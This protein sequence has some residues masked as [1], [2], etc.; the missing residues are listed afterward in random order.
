M[1]RESPPARPT[2]SADH[3]RER[4]RAASARI[5]ARRR[6]ST[7]TLWGVAIL[8]CIAG[9][10][11]AYA[12]YADAQAQEAENRRHEELL[13]E[14]LSRQARPS[15]LDLSHSWNAREVRWRDRQR[16]LRKNNE[17]GYDTETRQLARQILNAAD[18]N[19]FELAASR[20]KRSATDRAHHRLVVN[21]MEWHAL[22]DSLPARK[23]FPK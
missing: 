6:K 23:S 15:L 18:D 11:T 21:E 4:M 3:S 20:G 16:T 22:L 13:D 14:V 17:D 10:G 1:S 2:P 5:Q 19:L 12:V 7:L 9:L 8:F